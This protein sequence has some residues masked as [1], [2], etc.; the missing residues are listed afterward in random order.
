M[1]LAG[2]FLLVCSLWALSLF[3]LLSSLSFLYVY[4]SGDALLFNCAILKAGCEGS[5]LWCMA[6]CQTD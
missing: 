2:A 1:H 5:G 4:V 3:F 6:G